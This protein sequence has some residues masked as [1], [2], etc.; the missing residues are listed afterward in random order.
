M[1]EIE[2]T[3]L[4]KTV[5]LLCLKMFEVIIENRREGPVFN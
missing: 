2:K 5:K 3:P 1:L 4:F